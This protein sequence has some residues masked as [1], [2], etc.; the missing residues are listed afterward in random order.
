L[1][2][3]FSMPLAVEA[4]Q[5]ELAA[6]AGEIPDLDGVV[7]AAGGKKAAKGVVGEEGDQPPMPGE[8]DE[9]TRRI[10]ADRPESDLTP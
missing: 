6:D 3:L 10:A 1:D 7:V 2:G 9:W 4:E 8:T 5:S